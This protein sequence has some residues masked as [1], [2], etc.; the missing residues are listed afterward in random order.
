MLGS[1][2]LTETYAIFF[3]QVFQDRD[4]LLEE[5][6]MP[7]EAVDRFLRYK[8]MTDMGAA[9]NI[10]FRIFYDEALHS[11]KLKDPFSY[12]DAEADKQ[13]LFPKYPV[14]V[15]ANYLAVDEGFY[16][17]YYMAAYY[18]ATQLRAKLREDFGSRWYKNPAA[19]EFFK[20]LF[21]RGDAWTLGEMLQHIGYEE[22]LNPDYL[23]AEHQRRYDELKD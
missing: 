13:R 1:N 7:T 16:A 21:A 15:E 14:R 11:G 6:G 18:G 10:A 22:G 9:R 5:L 4:F 8:L 3:A 12:Y 2:E 20:E 23:V 19:G 17:L